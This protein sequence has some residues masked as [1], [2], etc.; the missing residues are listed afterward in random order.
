M[1]A[2][3]AVARPARP[4]QLDNWKRY[5]PLSR[6]DFTAD[7]CTYVVGGTG[8]P[9]LANGGIVSWQTAFALMSR[10]DVHVVSY[11][12]SFINT[13]RGLLQIP[14]KIMMR[15]YLGE[16]NRL[17][18]MNIDT[19]LLRD[20]GLC[21]YTGLHVYLNHPDPAH[22]ATIDHVIPQAAGGGSEWENVVL[23]SAAANNLKSDRPLE[24]LEK[25]NFPR[26]YQEGSETPALP[27]QPWV[28][29]EQDYF[30]LLL[31]YETAFYERWREVFALPEPS[32]EALAS[33]DINAAARQ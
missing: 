13:S 11:H 32:P 14:Q 26:L 4:F 12:D 22:R 3:Q 31:R 29:R 7:R 20:G 10:P 17:V 15:G 27:Y 16:H 18:G 21:Q 2:A 33:F 5:L 19:L 8:K 24:T 23:A 9:L 6:T 28:L 30:Y 25:E 1:D